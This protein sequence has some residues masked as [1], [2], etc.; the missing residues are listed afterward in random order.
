MKNKIYRSLSKET[1]SEEIIHHFETLRPPS[2]IP[3]LVDNIWEWMRPD[4]MP[5]RRTAVYASLKKELALKYATSNDYVCT[6][7]FD[8][9]A[10]VVQLSNCHDAKLHP[11]VKLITKLVLKYFGQNWLEDDLKNKE[12]F[13]KLFIPLLSKNEV[14]K[15]LNTPLL[16]GLRTILLENSKFWNDTNIVDDNYTLTDGE[17]FFY[18]KNGYYLKSQNENKFNKT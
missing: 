12:V 13:G 3:Y 5:S 1:Y 11:D 18:S 17:L 10:S 15:I 4:V 14:S 16:K 7:E 2:N 9:E 6:V 8:D